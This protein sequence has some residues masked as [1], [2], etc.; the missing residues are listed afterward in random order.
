VQLAALKVPVPSLVQLTVPV[1]MFA[2]LPLVTVAVQAVALST[3]TDE[4]AQLTLVEVARLPTPSSK[5][6]V[7][8]ACVTSPLYE[9]VITC[10]PVPT[11]LGVYVTEQLA[12]LPLRP[13]LELPKVPAPPLAKLTVPCRSPSSWL[14]RH[15]P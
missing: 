8:V 11:A 12:V 4:G 9:P 6:P 1:G 13:Q 15:C 5:L 10:V 2:P 3:A 14:R 7:L